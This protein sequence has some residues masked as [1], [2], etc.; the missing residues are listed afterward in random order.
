MLVS[1]LLG[2]ALGRLH[3]HLSALSLTAAVVSVTRQFHCASA[4]AF[5][6]KAA[7]WLT[8]VETM[9]S[10]NK[11]TTITTFASAPMCRLEG[12]R[13]TRPKPGR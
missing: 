5:T 13:A 7:H 2:G 4:C 8:Q 11:I 1:G 12:K 10:L 6:L 9:D 3:N